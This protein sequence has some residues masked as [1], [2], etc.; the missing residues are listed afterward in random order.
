M[1]QQKSTGIFCGE[2]ETGGGRGFEN[3][4]FGPDIKDR[5]MG[6]RKLSEELQGT[7]YDSTS[8]VENSMDEYSGSAEHEYD[9]PQ[10][11]DSVNR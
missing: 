2:R 7:G 4:S 11:N 3:A 10:R 6:G 9:L 5:V 1:R 8:D